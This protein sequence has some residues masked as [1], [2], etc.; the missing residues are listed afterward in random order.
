VKPSATLPATLTAKVDS[1]VN[2]TLTVTNPTSAPV[3]V[4]FSSGQH[5]DFTIS[6]LNTGE[7][8]WRAGMGMMF[9]QVASTQTLAP[10][11]S[12][13]FTGYWKPTRKGS[14]VAVGELVS[15]SHTA[16]A[17]ALVTIP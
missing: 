8:L 1:L 15:A 17:K 7:L 4:N 11:A 6:D 3:Q 16:A 14:L 5:N 10:G 2:L 13:T 12:L 9:T